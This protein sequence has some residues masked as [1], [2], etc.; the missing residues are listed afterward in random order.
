[1]QYAFQDFE[2]L[3]L[4][5]ELMVGGDLRFLS[6]EATSFSTRRLL[7]PCIVSLEYLYINNVIHRDIL[8]T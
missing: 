7:S 8:R 1:M 4:V 2:K 3:Y 5:M 6:W